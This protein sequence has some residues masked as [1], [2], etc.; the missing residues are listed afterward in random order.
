MG[1]SMRIP[2]VECRLVSFFYV[3]S[4]SSIPLLLFENGG[5]FRSVNMDFQVLD[6][7]KPDS[8]G[9][10]PGVLPEV[11]DE[12]GNSDTGVSTRIALSPQADAQWF[13]L[14]TSYGREQR[15]NEYLLSNN[16]KTFYPTVKNVKEVQ[17]KR[18]TIV[19][20]RLPNLFFAYGTERQLAPL[21]QQNPEMP[22]LRF[23]CRFFRESGVLRRQ[24][25]VIPQRQMDSLMKICLS[26]ERD[27][28]LYANVI[29]KFK[30]GALVRV[31]EGPFKGVEGRI[32][33]FRGQQ[34][35][36]VVVNDFLTAVTAYV[37][38]AYVEEVKQSDF[39][40][41]ISLNEGKYPPP[42]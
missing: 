29:R 26:E 11:A 16:I 21:V 1:I 31:V 20:S 2:G 14:K 39:K 15:A 8:V 32:A 33:R 22:Y 34:R 37:P 12:N 10:T 3:M 13:A 30:L 41:I 17:G 5:R 40:S 7:E 28:L 38:T 24:P 42:Y 23:Y 36:G 35:V 27:T 6:T 18:R 4:G 25:I 19:E 9:F